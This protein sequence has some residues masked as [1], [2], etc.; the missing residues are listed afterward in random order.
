M[1][2]APHISIIIVNYK[3][4]EEILNCLE[5]IYASKPKTE[6]E[7]IVVDNSEEDNLSNSLKKSFP[8]VTYIKSPRNLGYGGGNNLGVEHAKGEY[9]L[10]LNP[11]TQVFKNTI[12]ELVEFLKKNKKAGIVSPLILGSDKKPLDRQGYK[13]L[14]LVNGIF[15]FSFLRKRFPQFGVS[16]YY[17][18]KDWK[19]NPTKKVNTVYGAALMLQTNLF[20]DLNGFDEGFFLYFEEND[21]SRRARGLGYELYVDSNSKIIHDVGQSTKQTKDR[22]K[23][24]ARSRFLYFK[25]YYGVFTAFLFEV[26]LKINKLT[27]FLALTFLLAIGLRLYNLANGMVFIGD[28]GWFYLS[29]RNLLIHG[30]IPLVGITSSHTWLH[31]G[32]LWTY[33]LS[34]ALLISRF[35]PLS[36][37]FLTVLFG[38]L[39]TF[40]MYKLGKEMFSAKVGIVAALLYASSPL[41]IFFDRMPFDPSPIPFFTI[42]Y[43]Y[44][45]YK[46]LKGNLNYFPLILF[47]AAVLY[48]L[49]LATFTLVFPFVLLFGYGLFK[50]EKWVVNLLTKKIVSF[51]FLLPFIIMLPV[52]IYDFSHGFKQTIV[53]LGWTLYKPFS[54]LLHP[55]SGNTIANYKTVAEF[56]L[57]SLQKLIFAPSALIALFIF[58]VAVIYLGVKVYREKHLVSSKFLLLFL[59]LTSI[60]GILINQTPSDAYL[61]IVFPFVIFTVA[62]FF[63]RL[64]NNKFFAVTV[65]LLLALIMEVNSF[66]AWQN[67]LKPELKNRLI[68]TDEII[69]LSGGREYNLIGKG[70]GSQFASFTMNYQY[71]LW[72]KGHPVASKN[73]SQKIVVLEE[74]TSITISKIHD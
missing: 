64:L 3:V 1:I 28:Q 71:L 32:P 16:S 63:A 17:S 13:E 31:Q 41:I 9:L 11:D 47:F 46:W 40:V 37:G 30:Q 48:N 73:V 4:N 59:L 2:K 19:K 34:V 20:K 23:Y 26:I 66:Q 51:S 36:G 14:N 18:L 21:L 69:A 50:R 58:T 55:S 52:I 57:L 6:F 42:L 61:P 39:A 53:F 70:D 22:D 5:S 8:K 29:A 62:I 45:I 10:I 25:K 44:A 67:D 72:W 54:F 38:V 35:N 24:F 74:G 65:I 27:L 12:D 60:A 68:A 15:T 43:F 56:G 33:M 49:E 7:I